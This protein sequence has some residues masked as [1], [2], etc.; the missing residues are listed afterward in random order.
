MVQSVLLLLVILE[1]YKTL[2]YSETHLSK[3]ST[4]HSTMKTIRLVL[5]RTQTVQLLIFQQYLGVVGSES[6]LVL[7]LSL[8]EQF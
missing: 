4:L 2:M 8:Q 7:L 1:Y 6:V 5:P 3:T